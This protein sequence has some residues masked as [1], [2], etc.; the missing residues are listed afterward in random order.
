MPGAVSAGITGARDPSLDLV[1]LL[2]AGATPAAGEGQVDAGV[3]ELRSDALRALR[4]VRRVMADR[5]GMAAHR[6]GVS[7]PSRALP[8][9]S[10]PHRAYLQPPNGAPAVRLPSNIPEMGLGSPRRVG[11]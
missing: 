2:G 3:H 10:K 8:L 6:G 9:R 4:S 11:S 7:L 1:D 5:R